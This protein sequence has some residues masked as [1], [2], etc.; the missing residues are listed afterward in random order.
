MLHPAIEIRDKGFV[1]LE[2]GWAG[3]FAPEAWQAFADSW[4]DLPCD[5]HM[6]DGG[7][8]RLRRFLSFRVDD[9]IERLPHAPHYQERVFNALNGG[10]PRWYAPIRESVVHSA[11][12]EA[13]VRTFVALTGAKGPQLLEAHQFRIAA[14]DT[15]LGLPTPEGL[16][17]D[18]RDWVLIALIGR[19]NAAGGTSCIHDLSGHPLLKV[20]LTTAGEALLLDD[21][22]VQHAVTPVTPAAPETA[23]LRDV[24]VLTLAADQAASSSSSGKRII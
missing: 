16:H 12:F 19:Q 15:A 3:V 22:R 20:A 13:Y 24:L 8:Y 9:A 18:G 2:P 5:L 14:G 21:R 7:R 4:D 17:R 10:V 23:A 11:P 1:Q 6:G